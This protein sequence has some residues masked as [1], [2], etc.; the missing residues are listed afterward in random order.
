[1][2]YIRYDSTPCD[3]RTPP[4]RFCEDSGWGDEE[5]T[6]V[7]REQLGYSFGSGSML[8]TSIIS[9]CTTSFL[10]GTF[11]LTHTMMGMVT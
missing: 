10:Q 11:R 8:H 7:C 4:R 9:T 2:W 3:G 6:V 1:M 5:A